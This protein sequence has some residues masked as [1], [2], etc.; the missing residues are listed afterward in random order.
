LNNKP[1]SK[2]ELMLQ[3]KKLG[4]VFATIAPLVLSIADILI[5]ILE[6]VVT[7]LSPLFQGIAFA[8]G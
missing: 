4:E 5:D 6:P 1:Q 7:V 3:L 8:V 2:T